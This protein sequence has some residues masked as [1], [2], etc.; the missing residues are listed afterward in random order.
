MRR[1]ETPGTLIERYGQQFMEDLPQPI[2]W[3]VLVCPR[4]ATQMTKGGIALPE[5]SQGAEGY[6]TYVSQI[7]ACGEL[8]FKSSRF[9]GENNLPRIGWWVIHGQ[10]AGQ[11]L[12]YGGVKMRIIN[13]DEILAV[14]PDPEAIRVYL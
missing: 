8:A 13:D 7:L 3:R 12:E 1:S 2:Y 10:Y 6:L 5:Q 14:S 11:R 9:D 4:S